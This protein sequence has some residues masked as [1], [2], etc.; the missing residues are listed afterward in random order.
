MS[1]Y[2]CLCFFLLTLASVRAQIGACAAGFEDTNTG[3]DIT[4]TAC[5]HAKYKS[6]SQ[7]QSVGDAPCVECSNAWHDASFTCEALCAYRV[8]D[9]SLVPVNVPAATHLTEWK[10]TCTAW[11]FN[12]GGGCANFYWNHAINCETNGCALGSTG[13]I[14]H[15]QMSL[16]AMYSIVEVSFQAAF[17]G[18]VEVLLN[19]VVIGSASLPTTCTEYC[20]NTPV[21]TVT[22]HYQAGDTLK[23][24]ELAFNGGLGTNLK[25]TL[26]ENCSAIPK[27]NSLAAKV[28]EF[29]VG[30]YV[31]E[32]NTTHDVTC[33]QCALC[34]PGFVANNTCGRNYSNDRLNTQCA[35]CPAGHMCLGTGTFQHSEP[36]SQQK[37]AAN[38]FV[39]ALCRNTS[40]ITCSACPANSWAPSGRQVTENCFCNAGFQSISGTCTTCGT[41]KYSLASNSTYAG[42]CQNCPENTTT[43]STGTALSSCLCK[44]GYSGPNGG[45]C[46]VCVPG[47]FKSASGSAVCANCVAGKYVT[48]QAASAC[49]DCLIHTYSAVVGAFSLQLCIN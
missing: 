16:P 2:L 9:F 18:K 29:F 32:C 44:P 6:V 37:C 22:R 25:V 21:Q 34:A 35:P 26:K 45:P 47:T 30:T 33:E 12:G 41:G 28:Q 4:C 48:I 13:G 46:N 20:G 14:A 11:G 36:C 38:Q 8:F 10:S 27:I 3:P 39:T 5:P 40:N 19:N 49:T 43:I 42:S 31:R 7:N 15:L 1:S 24:Q 23:I 17:S